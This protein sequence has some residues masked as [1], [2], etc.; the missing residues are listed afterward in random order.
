MRIDI[1]GSGSRG[2]AIVVDGQHDEGSVLVDCGFGPRI[3]ADRM[4]R[5]GV[6]PLD[7]QA[8][9]ITHEHADHASGL[10]KAVRRWKWPVAATPGTA[11]ELADGPPVTHRLS[12]GRPLRLAGLTFET[13][14]TPHDARE[15]V[16]FVI[17]DDRTGVRV[18][19][20]YD[21]GHWT[22]SIA[23]RLRNLDAIVL[24]S[25]HDVDMLA[26]GPY[27]AFLKARVAGTRGHLSNADAGALAHAVSHRGLG[28][29]VLAHLSEQNNT[30]SVALATMKSA[31]RGSRFRGRIGA[32]LQDRPMHFVVGTT[33]SARQLALD[34]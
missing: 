4:K 30:P 19:L 12:S 33:R 25:N 21:L 22:P 8:V 26:Y 27:P 14:R 31:L 3:L 1:L 23:E 6:T 32:A 20:V 9:L 18:G 16:A 11:G 17:T 24:E 5:S 10:A 2:N 13:I 15:S 7:V 29:L 34:L 28:T